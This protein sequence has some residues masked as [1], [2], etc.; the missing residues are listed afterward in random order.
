MSGHKTILI[1]GATKGIGFATVKY[2]HRLGYQVIG[3]ARQEQPD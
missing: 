2:C 3:I 1:L